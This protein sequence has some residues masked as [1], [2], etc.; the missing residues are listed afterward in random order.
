M[1][2]SIYEFKKG[3][4]VVRVKAAKSLWESHGG[5]RSYIGEKMILAGIAN[6]CIYL[7]R[8]NAV[9]LIIFGDKMVELPLDIF[10]EGW[11]HYVNPKSLWKEEKILVSTDGLEEAIEKA[12]EIEDYKAAAKLKK[13]LDSKQDNDA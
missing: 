8:T 12:L 2:K 3:D 10:S 7:K 4:E 6:G 5:D 13:L 1:G 9:E 11:E